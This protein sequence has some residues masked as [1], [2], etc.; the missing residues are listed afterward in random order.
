MSLV[1]EGTEQQYMI[2]TRT[3]EKI[4]D[5][6]KKV[7]KKDWDFIFCIDGRERSGK[8][9]LAIQLAFY[10]DPTLDLS[11]IVFSAREFE[12]AVLNS[13]PFQAIIYDEAYTGMYSRSSM[14]LINKALNTMIAE[15]G[16][17]NLFIFIV[18][19]AFHDLDKQIAIWRTS[20]LFHVYTKDFTRGR[21]GV[22]TYKQ[23]KSLYI[24]GKK[25]YSYRDPKPLYLARFGAHMPINET[26]Y[27]AKKREALSIRENKREA[28]IDMSK[29]NDILFQ[30][31]VGLGDKLTH[32]VKIE[33]LG[34]PPS[35]YYYKLKQWRENEANP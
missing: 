21:Y 3:K 9:T 32:T 2:D 10:C 18:M 13:K 29:V 33:M 4:L 15:I 1:F 31:L 28:T 17:K 24:L 35:T 6:A 12:K 20:A 26:A 5:V 14:T 19:P 8:S 11:R 34:I 22:Y 16:Q 25:F 30:R 23:K 27:R 7:I